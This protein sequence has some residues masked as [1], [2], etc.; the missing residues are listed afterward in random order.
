MTILS[1]LS[2]SSEFDKYEDIL[3]LIKQFAEEQHVYFRIHKPTIKVQCY[4]NQVKAEKK[5]DEKYIYKEVTYCC[6]HSVKKRQDNIKACGLNKTS[7]SVVAKHLF[8]SDLTPLNLNLKLSKCNWTTRTI[9][10]PK[11]IFKPMLGKSK[12]LFVFPFTF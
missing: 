7:C 11:F 4:N 8:N 5:M 12:L 6:P 2:R 3:A 10:F 9:P 1:T